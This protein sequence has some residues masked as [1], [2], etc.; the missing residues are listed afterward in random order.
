MA[1]LHVQRV[2]AG[3][4]A[5]DDLQVGVGFDDLPGD[6]GDAHDHGVRLMLLHVGQHVLGLKTAALDDGVA[7]VL[8]Q[9]AALGHDFLRQ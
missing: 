6:G 1:G 5:H 2:K 7:R 4:V 3:A 9:L 8:Q